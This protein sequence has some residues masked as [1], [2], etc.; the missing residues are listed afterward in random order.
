MRSGVLINANTRVVALRKINPQDYVDLLVLP[1]NP[2]PKSVARLEWDLQEKRDIKQPYSFTNSLLQLERMKQKFGYSDADAAKALRLN[3]D[4]KRAADEIAERTRI[5]ATIREIQRRS[6][7]AVK[8]TFFDELSVALAEMDRAYLAQK[9]VDAK[10]AEALREARI[11]GI[12]FNVEYRKLRRFNTPA[13]VED[14]LLPALIDPEIV[15]GS[16]RDAVEKALEPAAASASPLPGLA[17]LADDD[18]EDEG[19]NLKG[20]VDLVATNVGNET[21][22]LPTDNGDVETSWDELRNTMAEA[23]E[24]AAEDAKAQDD[25][26]R[27]LSG[28]GAQLREARK[29]TDLALA[30]YRKV[31]K[32]PKFK[33]TKFEYD[34]KKLR[35]AVDAVQQELLKNSVK[36]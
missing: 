28:P 6:N 17:E 36:S 26:L 21:I 1:P 10:G 34:L 30:A 22:K 3:K 5:L 18:D 32:D 19:R 15:E 2:D 33:T 11:L 29:R 25:A 12:L 20:L 8:L 14:H 16:L 9:K 7:G 4:L 35:Q 23:V 24:Y 13:R 31:A 27:S